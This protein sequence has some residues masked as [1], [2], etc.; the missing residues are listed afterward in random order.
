MMLMDLSEIKLSVRS[1]SS[2]TLRIFSH[3]SSI[4][5]SSKEWQVNGSESHIIYFR[6]IAALSVAGWVAHEILR[7]CGWRVCVVPDSLTKWIL[8]GSPPVECY[9]RQNISGTMLT[10]YWCC[11]WLYEAGSYSSRAW[12]TVSRHHASHRWSECYCDGKLCCPQI[13]QRALSL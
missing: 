10:E 9:F 12:L 1:L 13:L 6:R 11:S 8:Q 5:T 7:R 4:A 3:Q 2:I